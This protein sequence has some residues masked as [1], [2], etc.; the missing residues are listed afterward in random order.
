LAF[1]AH[2]LALGRLG[3]GVSTLSK[4]EETI[5]RIGAAGQTPFGLSLTANLD[6]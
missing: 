1:A 2:F 6:E 3:G 4:K 5:R